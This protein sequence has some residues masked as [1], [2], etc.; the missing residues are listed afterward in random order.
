MGL[1]EQRARARERGAARRHEMAAEEVAL[2]DAESGQQWEFTATV[3]G[4][5]PRLGDLEE[6]G[7]GSSTELRARWLKTG[8][9]PRPEN[10]ML[11]KVKRMPGRIY[12]VRVTPESHDAAEWIVQMEEAE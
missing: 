4:A 11:M 7:L 10:G 12:V 5:A 8:D 2:R 6:G 1:K 3:T 9:G